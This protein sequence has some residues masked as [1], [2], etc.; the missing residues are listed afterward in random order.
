MKRFLNRFIP[1][2]SDDFMGIMV[3]LIFC[4]V[5]FSIIGSMLIIVFLTDTTIQLNSL[6]NKNLSTITLIGIWFL[7]IISYFK[8]KSKII[9]LEK[10]M[11]NS[12]PRFYSRYQGFYYY[13]KQ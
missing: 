13:G 6:D 9:K 3:I 8:T 4:I 5:L 11:Y 2:D 7:L 10:E 1:K 12:N